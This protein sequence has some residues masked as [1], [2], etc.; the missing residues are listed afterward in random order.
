MTEVLVGTTVSGAIVSDD[1]RFRYELSRYWGGSG[2]GLLVWIMLNP[3]TADHE[4]DD[5]TIR[6]VVRFSKDWGYSGCVVVNLYALRAASP[7]ELARI[8]LVEAAGGDENHRHVVD[9]SRARDV[10]VA[11][12]GHQAARERPYLRDLLAAVRAN[13]RSV[14][15]LGVTKVH[16][17]P[18]HPLYVAAVTQPEPYR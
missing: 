8:G 2:S 4:V 17:Q 10:V 7:K 1:G 14:R 12:G 3:S 18:R 16:E 6:R 13:A 5:P 15:C 9:A 11:W